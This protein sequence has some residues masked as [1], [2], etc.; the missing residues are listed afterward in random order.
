MQ[1]ITFTTSMGTAVINDCDTSAVNGEWCRLHLND[2]DGNS[3]SLNTDTVECI[4]IPGQ[5]LINYTP[6]AKTITA[7]IG[8]APLYRSQ[9][10]I[11]CTGESGKY[12]LRRELLNLFPLGEAGELNYK[13]SYG[14]YR[15]T[16]RL[17]ETPL[18]SYT[19][20]VWAEATLTFVADY[21]YWTYPLTESPTVQLTPGS[22]WLITP[23]KRGDI[24]SPFEIIIECTEAI[25]GTL[26]ERRIKI[27]KSSHIGA[28]LQGINCETDIAAG[29]VLKYDTGTHG[30]LACYRQTES[31]AWVSAPAYWAIQGYERSVCCT[32]SLEPIG[33]V[34]TSGAANAKII[35][36]NIVTAV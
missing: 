3:Q 25:T 15:I 9:N 22:T 27:A 23:A 21:P 34:I 32:T 12:K 5:R 2:F 14:E 11:V 31:G 4:G 13:N 1:Q 10:A 18:V 24:N 17:A 26:N 6:R 29:T 8:F 33:F 35:Y 30:E 7:K 16:A 28:Y 36:H 20:G 19:A